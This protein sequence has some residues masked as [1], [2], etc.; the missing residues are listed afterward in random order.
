MRAG[1]V[2]PMAT[3]VRDPP[4]RHRFELRSDGWVAGFARYQRKAGLIDF[5][6]TEIDPEL[7]GKGLGSALARGALDAVR[8]TGEPVVP[9][10]PFI[11]A[12][13]EHHPE[14]DELVDKELLA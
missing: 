11:A 8:A 13:I 3:E 6:H 14:Y 4:D 1:T 5:V 2:G 12:F 10:C 7:E 9:L